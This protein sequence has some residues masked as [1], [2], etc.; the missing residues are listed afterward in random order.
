MGKNTQDSS[1]DCMKKHQWGFADTCL[2][3][4]QDR[5]VTMT[6]NRYN[7][8]GY[9]MP[10][11]LPYIEN[12][13]GIN[14][15]LD[16]YRQEI[17]HKSI[18]PPVCHED[19]CQALKQFFPPHQ[20]T[21]DDA[22]RLLHSHGQNSFEEIYQVLYEELKRTADMVFYC[23]SESDVQKLIQLAITHNVCLVPFGGGT[24][25]SC[26]LKLSERETRMI[27]AV[28]MRRM[29]QM[30]WINKSNL[31]A[32]F[33]AGITGK[34]LE[35]ILQAEG[36][37]CGHE[38]D[39]IEL[40]TLGG[41]IATNASGMKKNRYG[42][43]EDIVENI[44]MITP[45]GVL[46]Q[47]QGMPR[48]AMGMQ[49][50]TLLFGS[51]GNLGLITKATIKIHSLPQVQQYGSIVFPNFELGVQFLNQL[52][53][54]GFIPASIRLVNNNQFCFSQALK[55]KITGLKGWIAQL[56]KFYLLKLRGFQPDQMVVATLVM[57]GTKQE[58]SY[59]KQNIYALAKQFQGLAAGA[60]NGQRGY[61]LTYAIAYL[62]D[63]FFSLD[64]L[65]E[66]FETS[67]PWDKIG[68]VCAGVTEELQA[69]HQKFNLPGKP[70]LSYRISQIYHTGV[71][72]YF[73]MGIYTKGVANPAKIC[74][75]IEHSLRKT[76]IENG[77]SISHH[78][79]VGKIRTDF[80]KDTQ[81]LASMELIQNLKQTTDPQNIFSI[82]N[83]VCIGD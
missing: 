9:K 8:S 16:N 27:I 28:D 64:I 37:T 58:V 42:N 70:Y 36:F 7:L 66:T 31:Q 5:T 75:E 30:E 61:M 45:T 11:L 74:S 68:Q 71:C 14:I 39:S 81:S 83:N 29:N 53:Y 51:E 78:H 73:M 47:R 82:S 15:E 6:G 26:A 54:S 48:V 62:R 3:I 23:E 32:C 19:F 50:Q 18:L 12:E 40:S 44:T 43:I 2:I 21:F 34:H 1:T 65:G 72:V 22:Q 10:Y 55:P 46:E 20:Y 56:K 52:A 17:E 57:E 25:V 41:W 80:M 79:G 67:V 4:N 77:G 35:E 60:E 59:Q 63:F 38:P 49:L 24:N 76:I 69:Q 13:L 33:Q